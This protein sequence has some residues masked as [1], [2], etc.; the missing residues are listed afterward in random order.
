MEK[1]FIRQIY[2]DYKI[3]PSLQTH[4]FRVAGVAVI[5]CRNFPNLSETKEII[6]ACLLH[7]MGNIVKFDLGV[8]S[9]LLQPEGFDY[10]LD[11]QKEFKEKYGDDENEATITIMKEIGASER[12][13]DL[14]SSIG[15]KKTC[16]RLQE[17]GFAKKIC[18]YAD[19]RVGPLGVL[20]LW[21]RIQEGRERYL[22]SGRKLADNDGDFQRFLSCYMKIEKQIFQSLAINPEEINDDTV[23]F[24]M[25]KLE[26]FSF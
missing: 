14:V 7:D 23:N 8:V 11:V 10:W 24:E 15:F 12:M 18:I 20:S 13:V 5:I 16:E 2:R 9:N 21:D 17:D 26:E 4:M 6:S 3:P 19:G 22:V 1:K 25:K